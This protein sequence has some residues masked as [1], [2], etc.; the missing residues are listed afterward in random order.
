MARWILHSSIMRLLRS[1]GM[2]LP[3]RAGLRCWDPWSPRRMRALRPG[4]GLDLEESIEF[5]VSSFKFR[6]SNFHFL[7]SIFVRCEPSTSEQ[8]AGAERGKK[9]GTAM[10][11]WLLRSAPQDFVQGCAAGGRAEVAVK[12]GDRRKSVR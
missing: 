1:A 6:V 3:T 8:K 10:A 12:L 9:D 2:W 5:E 11:A 7:F 4:L